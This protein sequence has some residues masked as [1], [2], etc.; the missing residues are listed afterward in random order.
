MDQSFPELGLQ[1]QDCIEISWIESV[2]YWSNYPNGT[3]LDVLLD[4]QP[5]SEKFLK[6]K[7][8]YV[9]NPISKTGLEGIWKKMMELQ[10]PVLT[11][12]P[13]GGKMGEIPEFETPFPHRAGNIY[14]NQY[15]VNW[16]EEGSEASN[17]NLDRIRTLYEY[18]TPHVS[19]SPRGSY[20]N[21]RDVDL[22]INGV[23]NATFS[24]A[25]VWGTKYFK[26][27]FDRLVE[28]KT[29]VDPDNFFRYE[30]SIPSLAAWTNGKVEP[31]LN[32]REPSRLLKG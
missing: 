5:E 18:M 4:R 14:K 16:K 24:E 26:G 2:L 11:F 23:G 30:Q 12:N 27:N 9:Q 8:D 31:A 29:L 7:S 13:Y 21:Y 28:I 10:K 25:S 32:A 1:S 20:L 15:S 3:S 17:Q 22:G 6:K 19:M